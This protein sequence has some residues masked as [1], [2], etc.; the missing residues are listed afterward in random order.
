MES[1]IR[2]SIS[3]WIAQ[4]TTPSCFRSLWFILLGVLFPFVPFLPLWSCTRACCDRCL[5]RHVCKYPEAPRSGRSGRSGRIVSTNHRFSLKIIKAV[6]HLA[7]TYSKHRTV[8]LALRSGQDKRSGGL[9]NAGIYFYWGKMQK[10]AI[11]ICGN[12]G[13]HQ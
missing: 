12:A 7:P 3:G 11:Y 9:G 1:G 10:K 5:F 2:C 4:T 6:A 13:S 8:H